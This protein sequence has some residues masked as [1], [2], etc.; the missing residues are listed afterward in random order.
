MTLNRDLEESVSHTTS[1]ISDFSETITTSERSGPPSD[2][3]NYTPPVSDSESEISYSDLTD[4]RGEI[5]EEEINVRP[6]SRIIVDIDTDLSKCFRSNP[7]GWKFCVKSLLLP[8]SGL[9]TFVVQTPCQTDCEHISIQTKLA[10]SFRN[11]IPSQTL[12]VSLRIIATDT[13]S[14]TTVQD[15]QFFTFRVVSSSNSNQLRTECFHE[16]LVRKW[17]AR[18]SQLFIVAFQTPVEAGES[19]GE[20]ITVDDEAQ[21]EEQVG[22]AIAP[23]QH[24]EAVGS[25]GEPEIVGDEAQYEGKEGE[26]SNKVFD[27][28]VENHAL[29]PFSSVPCFFC[30]T[31]AL[32]PRWTGTGAAGFLI[33]RNRS[34]RITCERCQ[35]STWISAMAW[36]FSLPGAEWQLGG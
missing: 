7:T 25:P 16:Q 21:R 5:D 22:K 18:R 26:E 6:D 9:A 15:Q 30:G 31:D 3:S 36:G 1:P 12:D 27:T 13:T 14:S 24:A 2:T 10:A 29:G 33:G 28:P 19:S 17:V 34:L 35:D 23:S 11:L 32:N 20:L 8:S 4:Q